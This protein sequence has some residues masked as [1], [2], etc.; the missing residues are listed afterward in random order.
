MGF[1]SSLF[2]KSKKTDFGS[3]YPEPPRLRVDDADKFLAQIDQLIGEYDSVRDGTNMFDA[4]KFVYEPQKAE[5][6]RLYGID[7]LPGDTY[8]AKGGALQQLQAGMNQRGLLDSGTSGL[9]ES[10]VYADRNRQLAD[11]FGQSKQIQRDDYFDSLTNLERLFP[12]RFEVRNIPNAVNYMNDM[13]SYNVATQRNSATEGDRLMREAQQSEMLA[14]LFGMASGLPMV[15]PI[16]SGVGNIFQ[17]TANGYNNRASI[18]GGGGS[19]YMTGGG[20]GGGGGGIMDMVSS[21]FG[22]GGSINTSSGSGVR[23]RGAIPINER[24]NQ[25]VTDSGLG[26]RQPAQ[27]AASQSSLVSSSSPGMSGGGKMDFAKLLMQVFGA[28]IA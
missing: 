11:L 20:G 8:G 6:D 9:L 24:G 5:L 18:F 21:L 14:N 28:G 19:G 17:S 25:I 27:S 7:T 13:N 15:G 10:Q 22:G 3:I 26:Y 16:A 23:Q 4:I 1:F 2:G 12:Q